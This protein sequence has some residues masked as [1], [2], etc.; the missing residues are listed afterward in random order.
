MRS[1]DTETEAEAVTGTSSTAVGATASSPTSSPAA[2]PDYDMLPDA[3]LRTNVAPAD[4]ANPVPHDK[5]DLVVVG[6]G[7]GGLVTAAIAVA[8]GAR[9]ALVERNA[10][11]GDC[12]NVGCVPSKGLLR[13]ARA[14]HDARTAH[15]QFG[16]PSVTGDGDFE[17]AMEGMRRVRANISAT[18]AAMRYRSM[19]V[20]VFFGEGRF[21]APDQ[22]AVA[23]ATLRFRRAVIATGSRPSV[24]PVRGLTDVRFHTN[25]TIFN[26]R[27]RP[28]QLLVI[29][30]G[31]IACE[32]AQAF[33]RLGSDV[34]ILERTARI[35]GKDDADAAAVVASTLVCE[36]VRV[37]CG[38]EIEFTTASD[39]NIALTLAGGDSVTGDVLLVATGRAP[40]VEGMGLDHAGVECNKH[41]VKT[42]A[43]LRTTNRRIYAVGDVAGRYQFTHVADAHA[44]IA[45][46]N[47]LFFGRESVDTLT[48]PWCTYTEPAL[49][50][51]GLPVDD[52]SRMQG[53]HAITIP[54]RDVDRA[55][56]DGDD[57]G[58]FRVHLR[59]NGEIVAA[60]LVSEHAGDII[61]T[62][63]EAM[64]NGLRIDAM[65][66]TI[67][68]YPTEAEVLR[69]A[70]DAHRRQALTSARQRWLARFLRLVRNLPF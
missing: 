42:D 65:G 57:E 6:G 17:A 34:T 4:W 5:Y 24:P 30:G 14:W 54:L 48:V 25:D 32:L 3:R 31:P 51:V 59:E 63:T 37:R 20:D 12:L 58:F 47:A 39:G 66:R 7:T 29:G 64:A 23:G 55:R 10:L 53:V 70:A 9:V 50:H 36:G 26:L 18:D 40:N 68:P 21:T 46:R 28:R 35:L 41:G 27:Q 62:V 52:V 60:T 2:P 33:R 56:L 19:G 16:G 8:L 1:I 43:R 11:G 49:A 13:A 61:S 45:A 69:K 15:D 44:R 38:V 67:F 22:L